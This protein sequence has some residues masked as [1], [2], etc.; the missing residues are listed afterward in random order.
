MK[1]ISKAI[2]I[3][4]FA[5]ST[6]QFCNIGPDIV[7]QVGMLN[8]H[9]RIQNGNNGA[10]ICNGF[11]LPKEVQ[12]QLAMPP[13]LILQW[14]VSFAIARNRFIRS[15]GIHHIVRFGIFH[16]IQSLQF[17]NR[18]IHVHLLGIKLQTVKA[19]HIS[20]FNYLT[21]NGLQSLCALHLNL[22]SQRHQLLTSSNPKFAKDLVNFIYT[23]SHLLAHCL[24][25]HR[26]RFLKLHNHFALAVIASGMAVDFHNAIG[27][28]VRLRQHR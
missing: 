11:L 5:F 3:I 8:I 7:L 18:L 14:V 17:L 10:L 19:R 22:S 9:T 15:E 27:I 25:T 1:V 2:V 16:F 24:Y 20:I 21:S 13:L 4:V 12:L 6:F 28:V 26:G 23:R